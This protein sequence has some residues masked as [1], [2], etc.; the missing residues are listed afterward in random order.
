MNRVPREKP[1]RHSNL[2]YLVLKPLYIKKT[3]QH[4]VIVHYSQDVV[5]Y[6]PAILHYFKVCFIIFP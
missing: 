4:S 1:G 3:V 6:F 5:H 2:I